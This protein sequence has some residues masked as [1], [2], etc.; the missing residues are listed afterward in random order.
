VGLRAENEE[1]KSYLWWPDLRKVSGGACEQ[2]WFEKGMKWFIGEGKQT[3]FWLDLWIDDAPLCV[4]F[5]R[6]FLN[7]TK[8]EGL[9]SDMGSWSNGMWSW[10]LTWRREWFAWESQ[11]A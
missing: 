11:H 8:E 6:M 3:E 4:T 5:P 1:I 9:I 2:K 7:S 10:N